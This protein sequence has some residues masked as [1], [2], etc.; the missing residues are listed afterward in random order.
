MAFGIVAGLAALGT[1]YGSKQASRAQQRALEEMIAF[2]KGILAP[3]L[4][5]AAFQRG[6][7]TT[8]SRRITAAGEEA[9]S[10][11]GRV[12][13][14]GLRRAETPSEKGRARRRAQEARNRAMLGTA[15]AQEQ[16]LG[17]KRTAYAGLLGDISRSPA[18]GM[19]GQG[20]LGKG[21]AKAGFWGDVGGVL[22]GIAGDFQADEW[23]D[24][25]YGT[26]GVGGRRRR[27]RRPGAGFTGD[28]GAAKDVVSDVWSQTWW[29]AGGP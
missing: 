20:I 2:A 28:V 27:R 7:L 1:L 23:L 3:S 8:P 16:F 15:A 11:I 12:E 19:I 9:I 13:Q 24:R 14:L 18:V 4:D 25:I 6:Q 21:Q 22:G 5:F 17:G 10:G 26:A 29:G